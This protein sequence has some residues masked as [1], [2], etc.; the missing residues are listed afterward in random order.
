[1]DKNKILEK[2]KK[3]LALSKSAN[4]HEA[5]AALQKAHELIKEYNITETEML[6]ADV[7]KDKAKAGAVSHPPSWEVEL[8]NIVADTFSCRVIFSGGYNIRRCKYEGLWVY[9]GLN[10]TP[11]L[12]KFAFDVLYR[13]LKNE[14]NAYI[15]T[16]L[17]RCKRTTKTVRADMFCAGWVSSVRSIIRDF[18]N[19]QPVKAVEAYMDANYSDLQISTVKARTGNSN[20]KFRAVGDYINGALKGKDANLNH[21]VSSNSVKSIK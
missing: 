8:A 21:G 20:A 19:Y 12:A 17:K 18:A 13:Q 2:I 9:I 11:E 4:E 15:Q 3:C 7:N 10:I 1:M 16:K 5:A 14:R 6:A